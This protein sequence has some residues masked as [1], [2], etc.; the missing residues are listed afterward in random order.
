MDIQRPLNSKKLKENPTSYS[1][2]RILL[3]GTGITLGDSLTELIE[4]QCKGLIVADDLWSSMDYFLE[5]V[6]N[7]NSDPLEAIATRYLCKNLCG[8][9]IPDIRIPKILEF[10][11]TFRASGIIYHTLKF[12][13]SY[14]N[15]RPEFRKFMSHQNIPVLDL[16]RDYA[17]SNVG[18]MQT[19]IEAFLEM[20]D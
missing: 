7:H 19:R 6:D 18:Q 8:R 2:R 20:I 11:H 1:G 9:M 13:D 16:D 4:S 3:T 17:E 12:C 10:C 14:A 5:D 15:L